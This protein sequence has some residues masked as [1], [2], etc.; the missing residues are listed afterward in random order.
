MGKIRKRAGFTLIEVIVA[1]GIFFIVLIAFLGSYYSYY[2]NVQYIRYKTIGENLAQLQLED[3]QNLAGTVLHN[4]VKDKPDN[5]PTP[6]GW[7]TTYTIPNYPG[8]TDPSPSVYDS[9][10][11][12]VPHPLINASFRIEH[13]TNI[14]GKIDGSLPSGSDKLI[15]PGNIEVTPVL[16]TDPDTGATYYDYTL[17]LNKETFPHY[18]KRIVITDETPLLGDL[19]KIFNIKVTVYWDNSGVK[20][21]ITV[22]GEK[23]Y[24]RSS[25]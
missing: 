8:D 11:G 13:L 1:M 4:L 7:S 15:L 20:K 21:S 9:G 19:Y 3:I 25:P 17:T 18:E 5:D 12:S 10:D 16:E 22:T 24:A 23:A 14:C 2:R 6:I